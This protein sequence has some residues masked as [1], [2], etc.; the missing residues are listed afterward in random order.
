MELVR[1]ISALTLVLT[2]ISLGVPLPADAADGRSPPFTL[3]GLPL[4]QLSNRIASAVLD[5]SFSLLGQ[6]TGEISGVALDGGGQPLVDRAV[7]LTRIVMVGDS[8]GQQ[9]SGT[10]TTSTEGRFSFAGLQASEYLV[11]VL[12]GD[13]VVAGASATLTAGAMQV[14]GLTVTGLAATDSGLSRGAKIGIGVADIGGLLLVV[15]LQCWG[16]D[17]IGICAQ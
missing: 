1:R 3:N 17:G 7:R 11:E 4:T 16:T 5:P 6:E 8:R 10:S 12:A 13:E 14:R 9:L 15:G 2:L